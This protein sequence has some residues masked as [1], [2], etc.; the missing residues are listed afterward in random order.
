MEA[1]VKLLTKKQTRT[2]SN[3]RNLQEQSKNLS[4]KL[5]WIGNTLTFLTIIVGFSTSYN[6]GKNIDKSIVILAIDSFIALL[7]YAAEEFFKLIASSIPYI[8]I[9]LRLIAGWAVSYLIGKYFTSSRV[10]RI[11]SYFSSYV[12]NVRISLFEWTKGAAISLI[13]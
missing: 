11:T 6:T 7:E 9:L 1:S 2:L 4:K 5:G 12:K 3:I 13:A 10:N 8:G